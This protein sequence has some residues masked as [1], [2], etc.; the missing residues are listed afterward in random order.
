MEVRKLTQQEKFDARLIAALA[1]HQRMED[2]EKERRESEADPAE[3]WGA[4][5]Q[6]GRLMAHMIHHRFQFRLDGQWIPAGGIGAV[7]TLPEYRNRGAVRAIFRELLMQAHREG[8]VLSALYP[9]C[10]AFYR[11]FGYETVRLGDR[12]SFSP[13]VLC[14][15]RFAGKAVQWKTG[16][17]VSG[18][19]ALY[20]RFASRYNLAIRRDDKRMLEDHMKGEWSRDRRFSYMLLEEDQPAA[21]LTF[22]DIRHD[23]AAILSV[24]DYAWDGRKGF[25]ALLGFLARF[26]ADYGS[27]EISLPTSLELASVIHAPDAYG[28]QQTGMQ[29]YMVRAV[30]AE[31]LLGILERPDDCAF[32]VQV[33]DPMIPDN[34]GCWTVRKDSVL[35]TEAQPDLSVSVQAFGQLAAGAVS[36]SE[37]MLRED[38]QVH[39]NEEM[40]K[41]V[42]VRK[43]I[44]I[45]DHY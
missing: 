20:E 32:T 42:F 4:F 16:D 9:F 37:A 13:S 15:Y 7:S 1:F 24:Q 36:L 5:D 35:R 45:A 29:S 28:I 22:Q 12:Y 11:K 43:P 18:Y 14:E 8:Q 3:D 39:G 23:P 38:V 2:P 34:N 25:L 27:I 19:T 10:H 31:K 26:S 40:L 21:F 33:S 6:D 30:H 41:R 44:L 17:P